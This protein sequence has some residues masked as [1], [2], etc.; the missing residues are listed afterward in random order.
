MT[1]TAQP[2]GTIRAAAA[3]GAAEGRLRA[4]STGP[5]PVGPAIHDGSAAVYAAQSLRGTGRRQSFQNVS[6][7]SHH[8]LETPVC[9][10]PTTQGTYLAIVLHYC[11][12]MA[13]CQQAADTP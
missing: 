2:A 7:I 4:H 6:S 9:G 10:A 13:G 5:E 8:G 12:Y 11:R 3:K 1:G